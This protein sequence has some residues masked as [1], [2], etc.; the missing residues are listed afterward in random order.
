MEQFFL[1]REGSPLL[2]NKSFKY[3]KYFNTNIWWNKHFW[4][5]K[6]LRPS[7]TNISNI[8]NS[9][10]SSRKNIWWHKHFWREKVL[11]PSRT[12]IS[13]I[14]NS[15]KSSRKIFNGTNIS[16]ERRFSAPQE[17]TR[18]PGRRRWTGP[19]VTSVLTT[20][21]FQKVWKYHIC[22]DLRI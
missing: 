11:R 22:G 14:S 17:Q 5:E 19:V 7:R 15:S 21:I 6:V 8:S 13:N 2:K 1:K 3:L 20:F 4:R 12:N 18:G 16:E 9:S 10:N